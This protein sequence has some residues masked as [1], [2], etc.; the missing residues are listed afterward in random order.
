MNGISGSKRSLLEKKFN[1]TGILCAPS[2]KYK[3]SLIENRLNNFI[4][5]SC[6]YSESDTELL[7][8]DTKADG[9]STL[10]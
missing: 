9:L 3:N 4:E 7:F 5:T 1:W 6:I 8:N 2:V 10:D